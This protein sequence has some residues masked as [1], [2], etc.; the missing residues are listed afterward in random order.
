MDHTPT[1][2]E[3]KIKIIV[4]F[5]LSLSTL[6][7]LCLTSPISSLFSSFFFDAGGL[8]SLLGY[9]TFFGTLVSMDILALY[10]IN[11]GKDITDRPYYGF[12]K[13]T[14]VVS[15]LSLVITG[16]VGTV[17]ILMRIF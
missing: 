17:V 14:K 8:S 4:A 9:M 5:A 6:Q 7:F 16:I 2:K 11:E 12:K 15:I 3:L 13:A 1:V 10:Y